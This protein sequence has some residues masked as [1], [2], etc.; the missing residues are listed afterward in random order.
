[1][2]GKTMRKRKKKG[3]RKGRKAHEADRNPTFYSIWLSKVPSHSHA[4]DERKDRPDGLKP[5]GPG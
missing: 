1:M 2:N 5:E 4:E 3:E